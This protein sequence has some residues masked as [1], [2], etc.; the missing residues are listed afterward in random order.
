MYW[1]NRSMK[2][3]IFIQAEY[4]MAGLCAVLTFRSIT[5]GHSQ[6]IWLF[7]YLLLHFLFE[8]KNK[9]PPTQSLLAVTQCH[10]KEAG[11]RSPSMTQHSRPRKTVLIFT[12]YL[13]TPIWYKVELI[14]FK[15]SIQ[16]HYQDICV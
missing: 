6:S 5:A 12:L 14:F 9:F 10:D 8:C 3:K 1:P 15:T 4:M 7:G 2:F 11:G 13:P 16:I